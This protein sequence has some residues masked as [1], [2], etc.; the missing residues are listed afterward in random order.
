MYLFCHFQRPNISLVVEMQTVQLLILL[1]YDYK[2]AQGIFSFLLLQHLLVRLQNSSSSSCEHVWDILYP[3]RFLS[4]CD[5]AFKIQ[6][7]LHLWMHAAVYVNAV[8]LHPYPALF[9]LHST[10]FHPL[11][12]LFCPLS[13]TLYTLS[14]L[15]Y[16]HHTFIRRPDIACSPIPLLGN[17][18]SLHSPS[19]FLLNQV[20]SV[21]SDIRFPDCQMPLIV[22]TPSWYLGKMMKCVSVPWSRWDGDCLCQGYFLATELTLR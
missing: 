10:G 4:H 20:H 13:A 8:L 11:S 5:S 9:H 12:A 2:A 19:V 7:T 21:Y 6:V 17:M 22:H 18:L 14:A 3:L 16:T 15:L 1:S